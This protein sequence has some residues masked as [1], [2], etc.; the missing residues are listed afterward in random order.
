[1]FSLAWRYILQFLADT[2]KEPNLRITP[3]SQYQ[4][5]FND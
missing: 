4:N 3:G 2:K 5:G 1:M